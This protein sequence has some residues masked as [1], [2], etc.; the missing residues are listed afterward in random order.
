MSNIRQL[1]TG[2]FIYADENDDRLVNNHGKPETAA[3]RQTWANNVQD[4]TSSDE[5]TNEVY[6]T[7]SLLGPYVSRSAAVF[8][9]PSD[10][11]PSDNGPRI[12]SVAMNSMVGDPGELTSRRYDVMRLWNGG[13][14]NPHYTQS[15]DGKRAVIQLVNYT[16]RS[17]SNVTL[18]LDKKFQKARLHTFEDVRELKIEAAGT[19]VEIP[20]PP[21]G[22]YAAIEVEL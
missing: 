3:R 9:C 1:N 16:A 21:V 11:T 8:K 18:G 14:L 12:R 15:A 22:V 4:W 17:T 2:W 20:L 10:R 19:G 13:S 7:D 6:L 5:N